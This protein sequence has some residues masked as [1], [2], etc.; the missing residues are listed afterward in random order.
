MRTAIADKDEE[1][2]A[3][4]DLEDAG[5][6]KEF[7]VLEEAHGDGFAEIVETCLSCC[8]FTVESKPTSKSVVSVRHSICQSTVSKAARGHNLQLRATMKHTGARK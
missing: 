8:S 1:D 6:V 2:D 7:G 5:E 3:E 4:N